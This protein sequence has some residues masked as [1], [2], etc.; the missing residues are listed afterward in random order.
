MSDKSKDKDFAPINVEISD[1]APTASQRQSAAKSSAKTAAVVSKGNNALVSVVLVFA[2]VACAAS[3]YLYKLQQQSIGVVAAAEDRIES[4]ENRL[5]ATG[6]EMGNSTVALQVKLTELSTKTEALWEQMDKL[7]SSA[8]RRNQQEIKSL[9]ASLQRYQKDANAINK[10]LETKI[11]SST[12]SI[13]QL[14]N[15]ID[16]VNTKVGVQANDMLAINVNQESTQATIDSQNAE[17]RQLAE[18]LILLERRNT[19]L[20]QKLQQVEKKLDELAN[21]A[22]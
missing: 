2:I 21:K 9:E 10:R 5:N 1:R 3:F 19:N 20:L 6:E 16:G 11:G 8:W 13:A 4:L 17:L 18:K 14:Q 7:W 22:V 12:N 15:R